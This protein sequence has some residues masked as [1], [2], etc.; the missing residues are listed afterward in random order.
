MAATPRWGNRYPVGTDAPADVPLWMSRLAVDLDDHAKDN[1]STLA[2]RPTS[3]VGTPGKYGR[4]HYITGDA[5]TKENKRLYRDFGT[6]WD[7]LA[8]RERDV[9]RKDFNAQ[10]NSASSG[11]PMSLIVDGEDVQAARVTI[12]W[13]YDATNASAVTPYI[14]ING[15]DVPCRNL[16]DRDQLD[17]VGAQSDPG[18]AQLRTDVGPVLGTTVADTGGRWRLF[19][20]M[21][22]SLK[23]PGSGDWRPYFGHYCAKL[24]SATNVRMVSG[25]IRGAFR[26]ASSGTVSFL[27]F[28]SDSGTVSGYTQLE[29]IRG[30]LAI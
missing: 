22:L 8:I 10:N 27:G 1:Q 26:I 17:N 25:M 3:S 16:I 21:L 19:T 4:Y 30:R 9:V 7:E 18:K 6:G 13:V 5:N 14:R 2:L 11:S 29:P 12:D 24:E 23:M 20:V 15:V 28:N